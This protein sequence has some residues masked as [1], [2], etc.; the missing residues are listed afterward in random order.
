MLLPSIRKLDGT[1]VEFQFILCISDL[2]SLLKNYVS[3]TKETGKA[4]SAITPIIEQSVVLLEVENSWASGII[5]SSEGHIVTNA[6][7][8]RP[9]L[10][11]KLLKS[12]HYRPNVNI[13]I[14]ATIKGKSYSCTLLWISTSYLDV[15]LVKL[16]VSDNSKFT[17]VPMNSNITFTQ[18]EPVT[19]I[20]YAV[21]KP[22][23]CK[24]TILLHN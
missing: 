24:S 15:A 12:F 14:K 6:H 18:G 20:G 19:V 4:V 8:I 23:N 13:S 9:Y 11:P 2:L 17:P 22:S 16:I 3:F 5:V 21:F 10:S 7:L 1:P